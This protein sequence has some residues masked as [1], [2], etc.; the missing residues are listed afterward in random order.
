[1]ENE[2]KNLNTE[3]NDIAGNRI[4]GPVGTTAARHTQPGMGV[5]IPGGAPGAAV[6]DVNS[7]TAS[8]SSE[9]LADSEMRV[10][11]GAVGN[12]LQPRENAAADPARL[13]PTGAYG[14]N[15]GNSTQASYHDTARRDNQDS[16][17]SRGEFGAQDLG[18]TTHGGFGNQNRQADYE[19]H[20]SA[21]DQYYG[22]PGRPGHQDN[23][24]RAYDGRD[25]RPDSRSEYGFEPGTVPAP[26]VARSGNPENAH[27]NDNG[28][29]KGPD[30]G[31]AADY[32]H[33]SLRG[34]NAA[35]RQEKGPATA[36]R[37]N[38]TED[39]LPA[40]AGYDNQGR[41]D[42]Q[43]HP[44]ARQGAAGGSDAPV[45]DDR[46]GYVQ[47][48]G[49]DADKGLG[50]RGGSYN[51]SYDDS[52]PGS[53]AGSPAAGDQRR[54]DLNS[55][56]GATARRENRPDNDDAEDHGTPRRNAGRDGEAD[57]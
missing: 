47:A 34:E 25:E 19:P 38:Q 27:L 13:V 39:Y 24:Y 54:E 9:S 50:S 28:A 5:G 1:M 20:G 30:S 8:A 43:T 10:G 45:G 41:H 12:N 42:E 21:E 40:Q 37:R 56:Y 52:K 31:Y 11:D 17:A 57:E 2:E 32:G 26:E 33:T 3:A 51:D 23:A 18:G 6:H 36:D 44:V 53:T 48:P 29:P 16:D 7:P 46:S 55:N 49:G 4:D 22:G 15:F 14:G 35:T